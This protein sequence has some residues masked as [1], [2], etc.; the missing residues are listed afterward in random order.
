MKFKVNII[1]KSTNSQIIK[2]IIIFE[3]IEFT[4][5]NYSLILNIK[6]FK[7]ESEDD[8]LE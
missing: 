6:E 2:K 8:K 3:L 1:Y 7:V 5:V 4:I